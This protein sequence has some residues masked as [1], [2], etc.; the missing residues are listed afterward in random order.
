VSE[1]LPQLLA[2]ESPFPE[3]HHTLR[4]LEPPDSCRES[5]WERLF[6]KAYDKPFI[7]DSGLQRRLQFDLYTVQSAMHREH[8]DRLILAYTRK[9]M[10]F[11]LFNRT[12]SRILL[13]GLGGG[14]LAKFCYRHLPGSA[15][16][17]VEVNPDVIALREAFSVPP[18]DARFR[19][20][21]AD[22][23]DYLTQL[24]RSKDVILADA[25]DSEGIA[26]ELASIEFYQNVH[27]CLSSEGVFVANM[28]GDIT[29]W[30]AHLGRLRAVF[31]DEIM[32]LQ[33]RPDGNVIVF[34]FKERH[35]ELDWERLEATAV[36]L[37]RKLG[38]DFPRYLWR[39]ALNWKSRRW[40]PAF[41]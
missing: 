37:K 40:Q 20:F 9:M 31:G 28:C 5:L 22:A 12:P 33:V 24:G 4:L 15:I 8:P 34:A 11:L 3:Q 36:D 2:M 38:M 41:V 10:A 39:I 21:R 23:A 16:T 6:S 26:R 30:A 35:P 17:A 27:R 19:V 29:D 7:L 25:C 18:D 13:L 32:T 1:G 14:S